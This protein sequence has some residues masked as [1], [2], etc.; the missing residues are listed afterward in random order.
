LLEQVV[1]EEFRRRMQK[2][3]NVQKPENMRKPEKQ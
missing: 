3:E 2:P 1:P